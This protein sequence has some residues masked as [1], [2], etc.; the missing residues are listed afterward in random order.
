MTSPAP[1]AYAF[2]SYSTQDTAVVSALVERLE[3]DGL[4]C[5]WAPRD[6]PGGSA[7]DES[8]LQAIEHC[9]LVIVV[10]S[11]NSNNSVQ[12]KTELLNALSN[13]RPILPLRIEPVPPS[14][15]LRYPLTGTQW[16]DAFPE[17]HLHLDEISDRIRSLI[18]GSKPAGRRRAPS[19]SPV[20]THRPRRSHALGISIAAGIVGSVV[21]GAGTWIWLKQP[22]SPTS[23]TAGSPKVGSEG[24]ALP[25]SK[26]PKPDPPATLPTP[27]VQARIEPPASKT[28][29]TAPSPSPPT[30]GTPSPAKPAPPSAAEPAARFAVSVLDWS[31]PPAVVRGASDDLRRQ[32]ASAKP[33]PLTGIEDSTRDHLRNGASIVKVTS[34][35]ISRLLRITSD[36]ASWVKQRDERL[37]MDCG[38]VRVREAATGGGTQKVMELH[39]EALRDVM[40]HFTMEQLLTYEAILGPGEH[41]KFPHSGGPYLEEIKNKRLAGIPPGTIDA[42]V[43]VSALNVQVVNNAA[44][45]LAI[46]PVDSRNKTVSA[47]GQVAGQREFIDG[48]SSKSIKLLPGE[49]IV[50]CG[51]IDSSGLSVPGGSVISLRGNLAE[52]EQWVFNKTG[53]GNAARWQRVQAGIVKTKDAG[54][55]E[56]AGTDGLGVRYHSRKWTD[57]QGRVLTGTA[58]ALRRDLVRLRVEDTGKVYDIEAEKLSPQD[59]DY[60]VKAVT[61]LVRPTDW[62][63]SKPTSPS[64]LMGFITIDNNLDRP[65]L[66]GLRGLEGDLD[67]TLP[68]H[69]STTART[70]AGLMQGYFLD[71]ELPKFIF[72]GTDLDLKSRRLKLQITQG[73]GGNYALKSAADRP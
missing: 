56:D 33:F 6:I 65:L 37:Q 30:V 3:A 18:F 63:A 41:M 29:R 45:R 13:A 72:T 43:A 15:L 1:G 2:V 47:K 46:E 51:D 66:I 58:L 14:D 44:E 28:A 8:I 67:L 54:K 73:P 35:N 31:P 10:F 17:F 34:P 61:P 71:P 49:Y 22:R 20:M 12:V 23:I 53:A 38:L 68:P 64:A 40:E 26:E 50:L 48:G 52:E 16:L 57:A 19:P 70:P 11:S 39:G 62:P 24:Q 42:Q 27:P 4:P 36:Q 9:A 32:A 25:P 59:R 60:L 5:W 69:A 55:S 7:W 21:V